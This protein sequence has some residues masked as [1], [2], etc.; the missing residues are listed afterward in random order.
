MSIPPYTNLGGTDLDKETLWASRVL[1]T[2]NSKQDPNNF[3]RNS[4]YVGSTMYDSEADSGGALLSTANESTM[5]IYR[6]IPRP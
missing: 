2:V 3:V 4:N 6:Y 5:E 1:G